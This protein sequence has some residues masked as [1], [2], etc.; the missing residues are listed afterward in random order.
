MLITGGKELLT[1][2]LVMQIE[3]NFFLSFEEKET[4]FSEIEATLISTKECFSS[5]NIKYFK[6]DENI[7][8]DPLHSD[9]YG[10][11]LYHL[12]RRFAN[13]GQNTLADKTYLLNKMLHSVDLYHQVEMPKFFL[14]GHPVGSVMGRAK[15]GNYFTFQNGCTVG[16]N[17]NVYPK[18]GN[19]VRMFAN[20]MIIGDC[21]IGDN[22]FIAAGTIVKDTN[23]PSN[24]LVFGRSKSVI[25][26]NRPEEYFIKNSYFEIDKNE[27]TL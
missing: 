9:Q 14:M 2:R 25:V 7:I 13:T 21:E 15:Y 10:M 24:S 17:K 11:F 16:M 4:I 18:I 5:I 23:I 22:V 19:N 26:K 6:K 3:N 8:F 20:S 1:K 27:N 12:S